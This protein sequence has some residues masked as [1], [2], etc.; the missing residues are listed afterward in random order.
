MGLTSHLTR[1]RKFWARFSLFLKLTQIHPD[2]GA[3]M[4]EQAITTQP[5]RRKELESFV[6]D[7]DPLQVVGKGGW[8]GTTAVMKYYPG[9]APPGPGPGG[10]GGN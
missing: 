5:T 3:A 4:A 1:E 7:L 9:D 10:Q 6:R 2:G 8:F